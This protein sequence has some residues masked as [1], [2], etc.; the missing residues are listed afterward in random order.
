[1]LKTHHLPGFVDELLLA[2][3][4]LLLLFSGIYRQ[5]RLVRHPGGE[6]AWK[7]LFHGHYLVERHIVSDISHPE[8]AEPQDPA[9]QI[10]FGQDRP[11]PDM[12]GLFRRCTAYIAAVGTLVLI[13]F[14]PLHAAQASDQHLNILFSFIAGG[15]CSYHYVSP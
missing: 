8:P 6:F 14:I 11:R 10:A 1:M 9:D 2:C 5:S 7:I 4:K 13:V 12:I 3:R 15:P